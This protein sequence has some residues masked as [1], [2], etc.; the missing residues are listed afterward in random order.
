MVGCHLLGLAC[1]QLDQH[2][3]RPPVEHIVVARA[4]R[5]TYLN[6]D[7]VVHHRVQHQNQTTGC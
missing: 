1:H 7:K 2:H 3:V 4:T 6:V 5:R